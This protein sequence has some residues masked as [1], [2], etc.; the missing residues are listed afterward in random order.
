MADGGRRRF[1]TVRNGLEYLKQQREYEELS[2]GIIYIMTSVLPGLIKIGKTGSKQFEQRMY[3]LE[4]HGYRNITGLKRKFAIEVEEYDEKEVLL[5]T[6]FEK[7]QVANTEMFSLN[8]DTAMQLLSSFEGK[9]IYPKDEVKKDIFN[10]AV[11]N[12]KSRFIPDGEYYFEKKKVS[13][14]NKKVKAIVSIK[15]GMWIKKKGSVLGIAED[16]GVSK[17]AKAIRAALSMN[18]DG[19]LLEDYDLGAVTPSLAGCVVLNAS[20]N[21]WIDWKNKH[22]EPVDTYRPKKKTDNEEE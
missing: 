15:N 6:I 8:V 7:S 20:D 19:V 1:Y 10:D 3:E 12:S 13:D 17:K 16:A 11:E 4:L 21:G 5:H 18:S 9:V 2:K 14:D 22:G